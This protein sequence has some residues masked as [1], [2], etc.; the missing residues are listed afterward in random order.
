[1]KVLCKESL[2]SSELDVFGLVVFEDGNIKDKNK[3][4]VIR[5]AKR[6]TVLI[7]PRVYYERTLG[8][9]NF[10]IAHECFHWHRHQPYHALM[11]MLGANDE[12]GKIIQCSIGSNSK[13][14]EKW[15]AIDWMEWQANGVAPH[16]LMP[17]STAKIKVTELIE[18]YQIHF[19]GM[20]GYRIEDMIL[21]LADFYGLSKLAVK[22][23]IRE[24]GYAKIDGVFTYVNGQ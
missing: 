24:M 17:T 5:N 18:K 16:I 12:L 20:D 1:M 2:L 13:D 6:G 22:M 7:D 23:R 4:I 19:D 10:T 9:V 11:K 15:K 8:T 21:E 14:S 3:N